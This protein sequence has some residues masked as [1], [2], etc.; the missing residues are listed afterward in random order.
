MTKEA[1]APAS[2]E[3]RAI[4]DAL[5]SAV[6]KTLDRKRRLGQYAIVWSDDGPIAIGDDAP[7]ELKA[8]SKKINT[9]V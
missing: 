9:P 8:K 2:I 1:L 7:A 5:R 3:S 4:L 6:A